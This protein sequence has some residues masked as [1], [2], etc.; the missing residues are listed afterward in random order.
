[1]DQ[2]A[3]A[4]IF[5]QRDDLAGVTPNIMIGQIGNFGTGMSDVVVDTTVLKSG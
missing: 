3:K 2:L 4:A 5:S 1:M